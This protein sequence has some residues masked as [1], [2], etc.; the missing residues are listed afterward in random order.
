MKTFNTTL[1]SCLKTFDICKKLIL[2]PFLAL[3]EN[4]YKPE[5]INQAAINGPNYSFG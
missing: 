5:F 4:P 2:I 3:Y 1:K